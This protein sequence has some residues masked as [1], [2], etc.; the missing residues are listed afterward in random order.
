MN[1]E[2][3]DVYS[4]K[5]SSAISAIKTITEKVKKQA[6]V[7]VVNLADSPLTIDQLDVALKSNPVG[8]LKKIYIM[9]DHQFKI[10]EF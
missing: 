1:G 7:I 8:G 5:T 4:P 2:L 9:K 6:D 3:A 10:T